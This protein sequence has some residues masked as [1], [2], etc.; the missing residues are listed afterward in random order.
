[1]T[2][3]EMR[4]AIAEACGWN[5]GNTGVTGEARWIPPGGC[6][7]CYIGALPDYLNDLNAMH[8]AEKVMSIEQQIKYI[9]ALDELTGKDIMLT[10]PLVHAT[11]RQ[12]AEAFI[13]VMFKD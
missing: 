12:R 13:K 8:E 11:T 10:Y 3:D 5:R 9:W 6:V 4:I 7:L 1:M 2:N